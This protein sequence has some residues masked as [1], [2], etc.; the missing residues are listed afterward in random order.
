MSAT[1][2]AAP[3]AKDV[4]VSENENVTISATNGNA[5][6]NTAAAEAAVAAIAESANQEV[7]FSLELTQ[8]Q[9]DIREWVHGFA[10]DVIRPAAHEWDEREETPWPI[11]QEADRKSV[12]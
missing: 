1:A 8:D 3:E 11:I 9:K 6:T 2:V 4:R 5:T 10:A 7:T 12:V